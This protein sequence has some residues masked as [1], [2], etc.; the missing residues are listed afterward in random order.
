M[1][2]WKKK[3]KEK[4]QDQKKHIQE[5]ELTVC[6]VEVKLSWAMQ[7]Q[8]P[9][10]DEASPGGHRGGPLSW[11]MQRLWWPNIIMHFIWI[12]TDYI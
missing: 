11:T 9:V 6:M 5:S 3:E 2:S 4:K 12:F 10:G 7:H 8:E 1:L